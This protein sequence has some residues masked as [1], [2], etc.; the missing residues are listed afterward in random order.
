MGT[1]DV[2]ANVLVSAAVAHL[3]N[4]DVEACDKACMLARRYMEQLGDRPGVAEC[5]KVEGMA[6]GKRG[7]Y[8]LACE[9]LQTGQHQFAALDNAL[10]AAECAMELG[11]LELA[12]GAGEQARPHFAEA[13]RSFTELSAEDDARRAAQALAQLAS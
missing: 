7:E 11:R 10:G 6:L 3:E 2:E 13:E 1:I 4:G 8:A 5:N 9:R 12:R